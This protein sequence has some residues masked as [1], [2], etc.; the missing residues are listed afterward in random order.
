MHRRPCQLNASYDF[1]FDH[2]RAH[3]KHPDFDKLSNVVLPR[4]SWSFCSSS[5]RLRSNLVLELLF[6][7][8]YL[9]NIYFNIY[10]KQ[11]FNL[12][13]RPNITGAQC[14]PSLPLYRHLVVVHMLGNLFTNMSLGKV[15]VSFTHVIK[16]MEPCFSVVLSAMFLGELPTPWVVA[17]LMPIVGAVA[18][19]SVT[20]VSFNWAGFWTAMASNLI[21]Q[22]CNVLSKKVMVKKEDSMDN[23][24][25]F[26]IIT[27][28][29]F[30]LLAPMAFF[31]EGVRFT[32][33]YLQFV[34]F[35]VTFDKM[36]HVLEIGQLVHMT[37]ILLNLFHAVDSF[38]EH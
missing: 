11:T 6:R 7:L 9:F 3:A 8:W 21:N 12:H 30:I 24:T 10:N 4:Q 22:S 37:N 5:P 19:A 14:S 23:I 38:I 34:A 33:A 18:L 29:S 27:I 36:L 25:L 32:P 17:S 15:A 26:S 13:K 35:L 20:K 31:M 16:T 1:R 28:M 2:I